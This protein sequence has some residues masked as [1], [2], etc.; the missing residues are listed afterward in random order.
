M[1]QLFYSLLYSGMLLLMVGMVVPGIS[2]SLAL[3]STNPAQKP[4]EQQIALVDVLTALEDKLG[5]SFDYANTMIKDK[6]VP[7]K[8]I[9]E[10]PTDVDWY[11]NKILSPLQLQVKKFGDDT[12]LIYPKKEESKL[13]YNPAHL[14]LNNSSAFHNTSYSIPKVF[15][16]MKNEGIERVIQGVVRDKEDGGPLPGV[17]VLVKNTTIGTVTDG[18]GSYTINVPNEDDVLVFST[19]GYITQEVTLNGR[20]EIDVSMDVNVQSLDEVVVTALGIKK[21]TK[22]LGYAVSTVESEQVTVNRT[23]NFI[24]SLQGKVAGVNIAGMA[25]GAGGSSTIRIRGQ[26]AFAGDNQPLIVVDGIPINN[27]RQYSGTQGAN[28]SDTGDGLI[29]INPDIIESMSVLK[30]GAAAALYG[31]RAKDGVIMIT[32]KNRRGKRGLGI[33]WNSNFTIDRAVDDTD[34]QYEYGQG[35][36]GVRP[37]S[38][39]PDSGVW[40]FG[41]KIEPGMTQVLFDGEEVPYVP[42]RNQIT[43]FYDGGST[44]TNTLSIASGGENGGF[45]LSLSQLNNDGITPNSGFE[46]YNASLG[47][48]QNIASKF[49]ISGNLNYSREI[50]TNPPQIVAQDMTST[51]TIYTLANTMPL[52][53]LEKYQRDENGNEIIYSR[54]RN[55]TNPYLSVNDHFN[56]VQ[57]DRIYGNITMR[58]NFADWLY[59]QGRVGQDYYS[60]EQELNFPSLMAGTS[61]APPGFINGAVTQDQRRFREINSDFLIGAEQ[62]FNEKFGLSLT[63]GGNIMYQRSDRNSIRGQDFIVPWLYTIANTRVRDPLYEY[64]ERRVNS[65]YGAAEFS[66]NDYLFLSVTGRNDWFS[67]LSPE[68]RSVCFTLQF[69]V[70]L[71]SHRP[72][73]VYLTG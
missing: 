11:L 32:T 35:E 44:F 42:Q 64:S 36:R 65:L 59:V 9:K 67:T 34:F 3:S 10:N 22:K 29:S 60:R 16:R 27:T 56:N 7:S 39:F 37:T 62:E 70:V 14:Q 2:Q 41:E 47:F 54:F 15:L 38:P 66:Y 4:Q 72:S 61:P 33:T 20:S 43:D 17:N 46:R 73:Q 45:N 63:L 55:R 52:Y 21:E 49:S 13:Q 40:S 1:A 6:K 48:T 26:S 12:Y 28:N 69:P 30:G 5:I 57:R 51:K 23:T 19:I 50:H 31:S 24:Q 58:Y 8:V 71:F 18:E 53:L 68:E 25:T